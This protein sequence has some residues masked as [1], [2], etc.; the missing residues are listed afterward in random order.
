MDQSIEVG[1]LEL[2]I[3]KTFLF[4]SLLKG[5]VL[6]QPMMGWTMPRFLQK[7]VSCNLP[8]KRNIEIAPKVEIL[9]H[10]NYT[11]VHKSSWPTAGAG[12]IILYPPYPLEGLY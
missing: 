9:K 8:K 10:R 4:F 3:R 2:N 11:D 1:I 7:R 5:K 12:S 6:S